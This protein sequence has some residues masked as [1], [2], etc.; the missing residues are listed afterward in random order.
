M[1]GWMSQSM[2]RSR[3]A[4]VFSCSRIG[5]S[6]TSLML[7][8]LSSRVELQSRE[9]FKRIIG[10]HAR[11]ETLRQV[12]RHGIVALELPM[13]IV[14]RKQEHLF[15]ADLVDDVF[16]ASRIRRRVERLHGDA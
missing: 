14:G 6:M 7:T 13:R 15:R 9:C 2:M 1:L 11:D 10:A 5:R 4:A 12:R 8:S 16:H 3:V